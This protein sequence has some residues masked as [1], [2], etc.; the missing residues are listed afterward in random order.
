METKTSEN[1]E[2]A[3]SAIYR[4]IIKSID[5]LLKEVKSDADQNS[6]SALQELD[7]S[8]KNAY[9]LL[10]NIRDVVV[11]SLEALE[12]NSDWNTF[13][14]AFYGETNAGKSTIIE[15]LRIM[16]NEPEKIKA[17]EK[18]R[19]L[20][21]RLNI[22]QSSFD[23]VR[24]NILELEKA[25]ETQK[26]TVNQINKENDQE[27][28]NLSTLLNTLETPLK[29]KEQSL[30][31]FQKIMAKIR[32]LPE[33]K[34]V[35]AQNRKIIMYEAE[36][37]EALVSAETELHE[38]IDKHKVQCTKHDEM[39]TQLDQLEP[40]ADGI[41]I[42]DGRSDYTLDSQSYL[43]EQKGQN[44]AFLDVPGI[45]GKEDKVGESIWQAVQK[46]HAVFYVTGKAAA[47]QTGDEN[48]KGTL[49]K[50]KEHL[51]D[52]TEVWSI[53]NKRITNPMQ[54]QKP[55]LI[56]R[57]ERESL[58]ALDEKMQEQLGENYRGSFTVCGLVG[59]LAAADC[60]VPGQANSKRKE[61]FMANH[62]EQYLLSYSGLSDFK[63]MLSEEFVK[64]FKI[65]IKRA[66]VNKANQVLKTATSSI[67]NLQKDKFIPLYETL[68]QESDAANH[69]LDAALD[70]LKSDL[71]ALSG[72]SVDLF[73]S[74]VRN[75][76]Y[77]EISYDIDNDGFKYEL[78]SSISNEQQNFDEQFPKD[79]QIEIKTFSENIEN[80]VDR[81]QKH[82]D[83]MLELY[84]SLNTQ[85]FSK[86]FKLDVDIDN[87]V[88]VMGLIG[89]VIGTVG[90]AFTPVGWGAIAVG[91]AGLIFSLYKSVRS[92]FSSDYK[93]SQQRQSTDDNINDVAKELEN[94]VKRHIEDAVP[95]IETQLKALKEALNMSVA[96]TKAINDV[97]ASSTAHL[98]KIS[99]KIEKEI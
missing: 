30:N 77:K 51:G 28:R 46:A 94:T 21:Q 42:G 3:T 43:V 10:L 71:L 75:K 44:F 27:M 47:P 85:G 5:I 95:N 53:F 2:D 40:L 11:S 19:A 70:T 8:K 66:N 25:V 50:I 1:V 93:M 92:L 69:Q 6:S 49:E 65:K 48:T 38:Y 18:F 22:D 33:K 84:S 61:K 37:T 29:E 24:K 59:F 98:D 39:L 88:N 57:G 68:R 56:S 80:I 14:M 99:N 20:Q 35:I 64:D 13:T 9:E 54:L 16:F 87:G 63:R 89:T 67:E 91:A 73:K 82:S 76:M 72:R 90:L 60:L 32:D 26:Q 97:L 45:E 17:Q 58:H 15:T 4:Q 74:N 34:Q 12:K 86:E 96:K 31:I 79:I 83:E 23:E 41:I 52:Q 78:K 81:F 7:E 62:D 55:Q 36:F